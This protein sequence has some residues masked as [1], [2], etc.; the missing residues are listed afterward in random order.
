[1]TQAVRSGISFAER[2]PGAVPEYLEREAA[3]FGLYTWRDWM[4][5]P[6]VERVAGVAHYRMHNLIEL[7]EGE[8]MNAH[9]EQQSR[10]AG[11][12]QVGGAGFM[13]GRPV[14]GPVGAR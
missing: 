4:M 5:L 1:M 3:R 14:G 7:H 12:R 9:I 8:A 11:N 2:I 13:G 6:L 10:R